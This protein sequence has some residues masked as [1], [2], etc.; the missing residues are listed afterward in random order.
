ALAREAVRVNT[1]AVGPDHLDAINSMSNLAAAVEL[2]GRLEEARSI[3]EAC[4]RRAQAR[5]PAEHPRL[6]VY[7]ANL[8]RVQIARGQGARTEA[9]LREVLRIRQRLYPD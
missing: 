8:A 7:Q 3:F 2:Q 9:S 5:V 6:L 4:V 1:G